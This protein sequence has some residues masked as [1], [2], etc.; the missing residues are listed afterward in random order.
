MTFEE[1]SRHTLT[2]IED[3]NVNY[4]PFRYIAPFPF[5]DL[6]T[7]VH[8][9]LLDWTFNVYKQCSRREPELTINNNHSLTPKENCVYYVTL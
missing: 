1:L 7:K 2:K 8:R 3:L 9:F 4:I 6:K 5:T